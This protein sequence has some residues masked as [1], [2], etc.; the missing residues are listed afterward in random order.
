MNK[1]ESMRPLHRLEMIIF[2]NFKGT[3]DEA[4]DELQ[5]DVEAFENGDAGWFSENYMP[6]SPLVDKLTTESEDGDADDMAVEL[7]QCKEERTDFEVEREQ[8]RDK[9]RQYLLDC[10]IAEDKALELQ[11]ERDSLVIEV[12]ELTSTN[13][14]LWTTIKSLPTIAEDALIRK[15]KEEV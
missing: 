8:L 13:K 12:N 15:L 7:D 2:R 6:E 14:E 1:G 10:H 4:L 9:A 5:G 3:K 11:E